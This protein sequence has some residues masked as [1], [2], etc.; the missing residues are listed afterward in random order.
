MEYT[1]QDI[2]QSSEYDL[3]IFK[4]EEIAAIQIHPKKDKPHLHDFD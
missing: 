1:L 3:T 2:L 4:P